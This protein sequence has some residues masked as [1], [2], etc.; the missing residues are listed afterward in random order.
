M[1]KPKKFTPTEDVMSLI[2]ATRPATPVLSSEE[3]TFFK[4]LKRRGYSESQICIFIQKSGYQVP[5]D[6]FIV[7][8][9]KT[10]EDTEN[11]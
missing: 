7:K 11:V 8:S 2:N 6:F 1:A 10:K 5:V 9:K 4:S 3:K